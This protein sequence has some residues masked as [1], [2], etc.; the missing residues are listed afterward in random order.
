MDDLPALVGTELGVSE[1]VEIDQMQVNIFGEVTRWNKWMHADRERAERE[2]PF[3]GSLMHGFFM[4]S[5]INHFSETAGVRPT[6][7][8]LALNYGC[9]K[10]RILE[11]V[12]IGDGIRIRDR[13][14]LLRAER[15]PDGQML[16]ATTHH[17]EV[18]GMDSPVAYA[19]YLSLWTPRRS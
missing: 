5:L 17:I 10:I 13:I 15:R 18:D 3:G 7:A 11:P 9:D 12:V 14:G 1:W 8:A 4:I 16:A 2:G 6:D 19:E